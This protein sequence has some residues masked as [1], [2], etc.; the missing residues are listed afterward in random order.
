MITL[1][2]NKFNI[3]EIESELDLKIG[4]IK[5]LSSQA[6]LTALGDAIFTVGATA[7]K[8]AL[9]LEAKA[10]PK[11]Y[12]H[13]YEWNK[14]GN[15]SASLYFLYKEYNTGHSLIIK[16]GFIQS[17]TQVPIARELLSPGKTGKTVAA[18][19][20]FRDKASI[21]ETGKPIIYRV[22]KPTPIP[23]GG[24]LRF[25]AAGTL[26]QNYYPGGKEVKGSFSNYFKYWFGSKIN[27]IIDASGM[28]K[29]IDSEL[30]SILNKKGAG[31]NEV[32]TAIINLLKQ[33]SQGK[34]V[35]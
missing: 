25:I 35:I 19:H 28:S 11:K 2:A 9:D 1:Q 34:E 5:E 30:A 17:R 31:P 21:M 16:P 15:K 20:I 7:F 10:N 18:K 13:I 27:A 4:G 29:A 23:D 12:H 24:T 14:V 32:R 8:K 33:Y 3:L 6:V 22:S 26:I